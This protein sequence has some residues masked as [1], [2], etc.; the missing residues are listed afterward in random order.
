MLIRCCQNNLNQRFVR[1]LLLRNYS[2]PTNNRNDPFEVLGLPESASKQEIKDAYL[3]LSKSLHPDLNKSPNASEEFQR[4]KKAFDELSNGSRSEDNNNQQGT[5]E[6]R[7][8]R[9]LLTVILMIFLNVGPHL[10]V[11]I[12]IFSILCKR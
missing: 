10:L 3:K 6:V 8:I 7:F 9:K 1:I 11:S 12:V 4:V 2:K 5:R